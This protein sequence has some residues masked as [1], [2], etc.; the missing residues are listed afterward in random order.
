[1]IHPLIGRQIRAATLP[2]GE[3]VAIIDSIVPEDAP[4]DLREGLARRAIVNQGDACPCGAQL[5]LPNRAARRAAKSSAVRLQVEVEHEVDCPASTR[6]VR[7]ATDR[8]AGERS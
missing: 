6:N 2:S 8:W 3:H 7:A 1:M 5:V 4:A